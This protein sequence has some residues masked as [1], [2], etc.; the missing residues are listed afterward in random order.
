MEDFSVISTL[1]GGIVI[2]GACVMAYYVFF[3][4]K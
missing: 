3:R 4:D 2:I 1:I